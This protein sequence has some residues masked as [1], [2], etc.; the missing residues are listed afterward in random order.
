MAKTLVLDLTSGHLKMKGIGGR[1]LYWGHTADYKGVSADNGS[2]DELRTSPSGGVFD[3]V[4]TDV[5]SGTS[6][7]PILMGHM[8]LQIDLTPLPLNAVIQTASLR[9]VQTSGNVSFGAIAPPPWPHAIYR[10]LR[11]FDIAAAN[12]Q[13]Y[14]AGQNWGRMG[15]EENVD[16]R[17]TPEASFNA[18]FDPIG[19]TNNPLN[20]LSL[21][22]ANLVRFF[23]ATDSRILQALV[24]RAVAN[25]R[26][27]PTYANLAGGG[28]AEI[29]W[30]HSVSFQP[31]L[32]I[33]YVDAL[34]HHPADDGGNIDLTTEIDTTAAN[35]Y[36]FDPIRIG[37]FGGAKKFFTK[38]QMSASA[39]NLRVISRRSYPS[40]PYEVTRSAVG[41]G[42]L[43][44]I[45]TVDKSVDNV[46]YTRSERWKIVFETGDA[47]LDQF[48]VYHDNGTLDDP[49]VADVW[50]AANPPTGTL[51][52]A[53]LEADRKVGF[54]LTDDG[55]TPFDDDDE[56]FF[57]TFEDDAHPAVPLDSDYRLEIAPDVD[58]AP[59]DFRPLVWKPMLAGGAV[60]GAT[61]IPMADTSVFG[62]NQEVKIYRRT[63]GVLLYTREVAAIVENT[64]ITVDTAVTIS[65]G[66]VVIPTP[67]GTTV[68][69]AGQTFPYWLRAWAPAGAV[70]ETK[71]PR[72]GARAD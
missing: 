24:T 45:T 1:S 16:F 71:Y 66:D 68:L 6:T 57:Q 12:F 70:R 60:A 49:S 10:S 17:G 47:V 48:H 9:L 20:V 8:L 11:T 21:D 33:T 56:I 50:S 72:W 31:R 18:I 65:S 4:V 30:N 27:Y 2:V 46:A 58:N 3:G 35:I 15:L 37:T 5:C 32:T 26:S 14:A 19:P 41:D 38:N 7:G 23:A 22:I 52:V 55:G 43:S 13:E 54:T 28:G 25:R 44:D 53:Y 29:S 62:L 64:S 61:I 36:L 63:D 42:T 69:A 40:M 39:P 34:S 67:V 51:G 59:A